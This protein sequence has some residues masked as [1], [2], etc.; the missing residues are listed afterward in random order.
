MPGASGISQYPVG[1]KRFDA[2]LDPYSLEA[3]PDYFKYRQKVER[4]YPKYLTLF[5]DNDS[6]YASKII[7]GLSVGSS[8]GGLLSVMEY[9][10][11]RPEQH[12][13]SSALT[14]VKLVAVHF[15]RVFSVWGLPLVIAGGLYGTTVSLATNLRGKE[16]SLNHAVAGGIGGVLF[17]NT[18]P[19]GKVFKAFHY[20]QQGMRH[21]YGPR[22]LA[23]ICLGVGGSVLCGGFKELKMKT[24]HMPQLIT[25]VS[26]LRNA[27]A[28]Q[29]SDPRQG[30][31]SRTDHVGPDTSECDDYNDGTVFNKHLNKKRL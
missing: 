12:I 31:F 9:Y 3:R 21:L 7:S 8:A 27:I 28:S 5:H 18:H 14:R 16:D 25:D 1:Q 10:K 20:A 22:T 23:M 4:N 29:W 11:T 6:Q 2:T 19:W 26:Q 13:Y 15:T 24:A 30:V 17:A